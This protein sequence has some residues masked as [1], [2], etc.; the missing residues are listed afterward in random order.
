MTS[1]NRGSRE[2]RDQS[3]DS[4]RLHDALD[5]ARELAKRS[6]D[7]LSLENVHFAKRYREQ[8][9]KIHVH[10][11]RGHDGS[12]QFC[13]VVYGIQRSE[14][15]DVNLTRETVRPM[16]GGF[17]P[18]PN[19][20][21]SIVGGDEEPVLVYV[22]DQVEK[23]QKI[24]PTFVRFDLLEKAHKSLTLGLFC[25]SKFGIQKV[26]GRVDPESFAIDKR[27][28]LRAVDLSPEKVEGGAK[29]VNGISSDTSPSGREFPGDAGKHHQLPR[30]RIVLSDDG[31]WVG[32]S[33]GFDLGF[34]IVDVLYGPFDLDPT[35]GGPSG[36]EA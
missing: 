8:K 24:V 29:I 32:L 21:D 13:A 27:A 26:G 5:F 20:I 3:G 2:L 12:P 18:E 15:L 7:V 1:G 11:S 9:L 36:H 10:L 33:K 23:A 14:S 6:N 16:R 19:G 28:E 35:A 34:E 4:K 17:G 25:S 22:V 30:L 31:I